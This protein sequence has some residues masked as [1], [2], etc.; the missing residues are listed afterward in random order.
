MEEE[1]LLKVLIVGSANVGKTALKERLINNTFSGKYTQSE[2]VNFGAIILEQSR[3]QLWDVSSTF[4][5]QSGLLLAGMSL[6]LMV[7]DKNN[8]DSFV[9]LETWLGILSANGVRDIPILFVQNKSDF[10]TAHIADK[11][12]KIIDAWA[13]QYGFSPMGVVAYS[14]ETDFNRDELNSGLAQGADV[15]IARMN[16]GKQETVEVVEPGSVNLSGRDT[17]QEVLVMAEK[18][19]RANPF[20]E[21]LP[22]LIL[23]HLP[24]EQQVLSLLERSFGVRVSAMLSFAEAATYNERFLVRTRG[25]RFEDLKST[26]LSLRQ[27][28]AHAEA[29]VNK[30]LIWLLLHL[31]SIGNRQSSEVSHFIEACLGKYFFSAENC[32]SLF[33]EHVATKLGYVFCDNSITVG[34]V[35]LNVGEAVS[36]REIDMRCVLELLCEADVQER[37]TFALTQA[38]KARIEATLSLA[39]NIFYVPNFSVENALAQADPKIIS[40]K[41]REILQ[42][43][44]PAVQIQQHRPGL[45]AIM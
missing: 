29:D 39:H 3:L 33:Q 8:P 41:T 31:V 15:A 19:I 36:H 44:F 43:Y 7:W 16:K 37:A 35:N 9:Q 1:V 14:A 18:S 38:S 28:D 21:Q 6:M 26:V 40:D 10:D 13:L 25:K 32:A 23:K 17:Q 24:E 27:K 45:C 11:Y 4:S 30:T 22:K 34:A 5:D 42:H 12:R 20:V 2:Q